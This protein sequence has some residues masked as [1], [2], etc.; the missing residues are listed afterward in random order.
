MAHGLHSC[1]GT[2]EVFHGSGASALASRQLEASMFF[3]ILFQSSIGRFGDL[4]RARYVMQ[5]V[6]LALSA[7]VA[8][9]S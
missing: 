4:V 6:H 5:A 9:E 2:L 8:P 7:E 1:P 3:S